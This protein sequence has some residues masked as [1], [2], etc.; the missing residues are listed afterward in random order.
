MRGFWLLAGLLLALTASAEARMHAPY[1]GHRIVS[2]AAPLD[3]YPAPMVA[4]GFRKLLSS[5]NGPGVNLR[6][7]SDNA[8]LDIN[9]LGF[10]PGIGAP[11]DIAAANTFC[12][13]TTC[14]IPWI[15]N[16]G[17]A[18]DISAQFSAGSQPQFVANCQNNSP[19][20]RFINGGQL[21]TPTAL[22]WVATS[23]ISVVAKRTS[24]TGQCFLM[25]KGDTIGIDTAPGTWFLY[26]FTNYVPKTGI[27]ENTWHTA[28]ASIAGAASVFRI[29]ASETAATYPGFAGL[30]QAYWHGVAAT[31]C[32]WA[33]GIIWDGTA[34][35]PAERAV[36]HANQKSFWG[37]P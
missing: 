36:L 22:T 2:Q 1:R 9:Y 15:F 11:L 29:D 6:R 14:F 8:T 10:V 30:A 25:R 33:E 21:A 24:G 19:C 7:A 27:T 3:G 34:F 13:A 31:S 28:M 26:D 17:T 32:D 35:S 18:G 37:T 16:Q 12:A 20:M 23:T 5:Y 4:F